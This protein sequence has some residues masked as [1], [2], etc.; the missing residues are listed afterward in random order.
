MKRLIVIQLFVVLFITSTAF[1]KTNSDSFMTGRDVAKNDA[2]SNIYLK[3]NGTSSTI[4]YGLYI[5]QF[6]LVEPNN[7]CDQATEIYPNGTTSLTPNITAGS[8]VMPTLIKPGQSALVGSNYLYNMIYTANY[9]ISI[10]IPTSPPG[11]SLPGCTWGD[12]SGK[13]IYNWCIYLGALAPVTRSA[14]YTANV[15]PPAE[16]A[17]SG[18]DYNYNLISDSHYAYLGPISCDDQTLTCSVVAKQTQSFP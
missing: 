11:C 5:R 17:S 15:P 10:N 12:D 1:A 18:T 2:V 16:L 4:V 14:D 13:P 6:A 3:N 8:M 9:Y 7:T